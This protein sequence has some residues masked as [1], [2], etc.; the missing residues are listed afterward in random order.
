M[1]AGEGDVVAG[2][3]GPIGGNG[4][5]PVGRVGVGGGHCDESL[6]RSEFGRDG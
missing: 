4:R 3:V 5:G 2:G 6:D 1:R